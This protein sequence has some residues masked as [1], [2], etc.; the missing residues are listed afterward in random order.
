MPRLISAS[1]L[2]KS[3]RSVNAN[4]DKSDRLFSRPSHGAWVRTQSRSP[5]QLHSALFMRRA[6]WR[7]GQNQKFGSDDDFAPGL[8]LRMATSVK[9]MNFLASPGSVPQ[10]TPKR[11]GIELAVLHM[12]PN[13][14]PKDWRLDADAE[15]C[16]RPNSRKM[17]W[18][19][20]VCLDVLVRRQTGKWS[21]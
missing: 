9:A 19:F 18:I 14:T 4:V 13:H 16:L 21:G 15:G 11:G 7:T 6:C 8:A 1:N 5:M 17:P 20:G 3:G 10:Y 2:R 12:P